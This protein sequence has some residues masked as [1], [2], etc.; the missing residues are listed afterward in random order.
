[1][2]AIAQVRDSSVLTPKD[3]TLS[4]A[5]RTNGLF[6]RPT[7]A[8]NGTSRAI[9]REALRYYTSP[10]TFSNLLEEIGG[11]YPL[12][13]SDEG[14]G[15]ESFLFTGRINEPLAV[16]LINGVLPINDPLTGNTMLNYFPLETFDRITIDNGASGLSKTGAS[17]VGSDAIDFTLERFRAPIPFSRIHYT[18]VLAQSLSN[19]D[20]VFSVNASQPVNIAAG[21]SHRAAGRNVGPNDVTFNP[22]VESWSARAQMTYQSILSK[23]KRDSTMSDRIFDSLVKIST[24]PKKAVDLIVWGLYTS[25]FSGLNGGL[26]AQD[27]QDVFNPQVNQVFFQNTYDHRVRMDGLVQI[28]LPFLGEDRTQLSAYAT[29]STRRFGNITTIFSPFITDFTRSARYGAALV[30]PFALEIG[31]FITRAVI[32]GNA[33]ILNKGQ[34]LNYVPDVNDIR[35]SASISDS[36]AFES[37]LGISLFGYARFTQSNL[38]LDGAAAPS[39][40]FPNIGLSASTKLSNA[41]RFTATYDYQKDRASLSPSPDQEYQLRN[42]GGFIDLRTA[43]SRRDSVAIRAGVLDRNEPEGIVYDFI[44]D[45]LAKPRFS[46]ANLHS[47]SG[48]IYLDLYIGQ[49]HLSS[50]LTYFP[51][52]VP[53]TRFTANQA[54]NTSLTQRFFGYAG[55]YYEDEVGEGNLR[56]SLGGRVRFQDRLDPSYSYDPA[57]DYYVYRGA[58]ARGTK[59]LFEQDDRVRKLQGMIDILLSTEVDRRAQVNMSFLNILGAPYY[60]TAI[61]PR[62]GFQWRV[63]VTWAFLD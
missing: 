52:T 59:A 63:D 60:N 29:Y 15:R 3:T 37:T 48:V 38:Q 8:N 45:T 9:S 28:D 58:A 56:L 16:T 26:N 19:F 51:A 43:L 5:E 35:F 2:N 57:A 55:L 17:N 6:R 50:N 30:Q 31:N 13:L 39:L 1:M 54:L 49:F 61:Y 23:V 11:A 27:S 33:E 47:Q 10:M 14:Y 62:A 4:Q 40:L 21:L 53:I 20:G 46:N 24:N 18:Q 44:G 34:I 7:V 41:V 36:L 22:R 25:T 42:L 32:K 12:L